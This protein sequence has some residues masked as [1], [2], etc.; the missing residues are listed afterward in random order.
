MAFGLWPGPRAGPAPGRGKNGWRR[1]TATGGAGCELLSPPR[2]T[3]EHEQP[4]AAWQAGAADLGGLGATQCEQTPAS[5][6]SLAR[7][8]KRARAGGNQRAPRRTPV[9]S[10]MKVNWAHVH[11]PG[12][13]ARIPNSAH[14]DRFKHRTGRTAP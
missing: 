1:I 8:I 10:S 13:I 3:E 14:A 6:A 11:R 5:T 4:S 12:T 7:L 2:R 9:Q